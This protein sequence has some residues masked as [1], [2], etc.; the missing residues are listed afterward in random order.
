[1]MVL[2]REYEFTISET[3][4]RTFCITTDTLKEVNFEEERTSF[5]ERRNLE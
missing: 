1:M 2:N 5:T 4:P 3:V